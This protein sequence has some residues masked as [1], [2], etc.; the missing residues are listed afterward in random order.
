MTVVSNYLLQSL[1]YSMLGSSGVSGEASQVWW[2][3]YDRLASA[4]VRSSFVRGVCF[5]TV[6]GRPSS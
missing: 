3:R 1:K 6:E 5:I 4:V 2:V